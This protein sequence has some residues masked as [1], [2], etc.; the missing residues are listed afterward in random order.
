M[1]WIHMAMDM[2]TM[3]RQPVPLYFR[4]HHT[5]SQNMIGHLPEH[6]CIHLQCWQQSV[7][8]H[9]VSL[10]SLF[11]FRRW[12]ETRKSFIQVKM[13]FSFG[14]KMLF[15]WIK[16][17]HQMKRKRTRC[18]QPINFCV[19]CYGVCACAHTHQ[20]ENWWN[21]VNWEKRQMKSW[22]I[23][24]NEINPYNS[25]SSSESF[26]LMTLALPFD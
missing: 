3:H 8:F 20:N 21:E 26:A 22:K 6:F 24:W 2:R 10:C 7:S 5:V 25:C 1:K 15:E 11:V 13:S 16:S 9:L 14:F 23:C 19:N 12:W 17:C 18:A 4:I